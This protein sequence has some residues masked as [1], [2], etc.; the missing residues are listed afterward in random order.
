MSMQSSQQMLSNIKETKARK[1]RRKKLAINIAKFAWKHKHEII[2]G[3][4]TLAKM[5]YDYVFFSSILSTGN[6]NTYGI[7][8]NDRSRGHPNFNRSGT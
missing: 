7:N 2:M 1:E 6:I 5:R 3:I 4:K 8:Y